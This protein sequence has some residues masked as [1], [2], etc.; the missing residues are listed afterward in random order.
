MG[1]ETLL[2]IDVNAA[3][4]E[5]LAGA[6]APTRVLAVTSTQ[7]TA[8]V[9]REQPLAL[10]IDLSRTPSPVPLWLQLSNGVTVVP[11]VLWVPTGHEAALGPWV[12]AGARHWVHQGREAEW[13]LVLSLVRLELANEQAV[14]AQRERAH[15]STAALVRLARSP[16][17]TG[18]DVEAAIREVTR[19]AARGLQATRAGVWL[20]DERRELLRL[21]D[22]FPSVILLGGA[23]L[24]NREIVKNIGFN[25]VWRWQDKVLWESTLANG[26]VPAYNT[27]DAQVSWSIP[28]LRSKV[29][30]GATNLFNQRYY[31][32]AAG[33]TIGG[34]YYL[35]VTYDGTVVR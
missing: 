18:S 12:A 20:L 32:F 21:V 22:R 3:T 24:G 2:S 4:L 8:E 33:P 28:S 5:R 31:Q 23:V 6:C 34:L 30:L 9:Q 1:S 7:V 29:K 19:A 10:I 16:R 11:V 26:Q 35:A 27:I 15:Q 13:P 14:T 17:V 25:L